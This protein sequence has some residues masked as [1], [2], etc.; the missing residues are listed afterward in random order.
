MQNTNIHKKFH[1]EEM[2]QSP[3]WLVDLY[4]DYYRVVENKSY[5]I[6]SLSSF[7]ICKFLFKICNAMSTDL[8]K[9]YRMWHPYVAHTCPFPTFSIVFFVAFAKCCFLVSWHGRAAAYLSRFWNL[10]CASLSITGISTSADLPP[11]YCV[12][13]K[14]VCSFSWCACF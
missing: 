14:E 3:E 9:I 1:T 7:E 13:F 2:S 6:L 10:P 5:L 4:V 8:L 12:L 11:R